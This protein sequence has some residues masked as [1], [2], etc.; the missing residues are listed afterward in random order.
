MN[1]YAPSFLHFLCLWTCLLLAQTTMG[2]GA[3]R[4]LSRTYAPSEYRGATANWSMVQD[5]RGRLCVANARGVLIYDGVHWRTV[6]VSNGSFVR[7][8]AVTQESRA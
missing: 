8:L 3:A 5:A 2:Q 4:W 6:R 1:R 7:S